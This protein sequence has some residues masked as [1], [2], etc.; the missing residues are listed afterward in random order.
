MMIL[1]LPMSLFSYSI[2]LGPI[3]IP[4]F[5]NTIESEIDQTTWS[6][7]SQ[8][9]NLAS[10]VSKEKVLN[11]Q[12]E[13]EQSVIIRDPYGRSMAKRH[14]LSTDDQG[15][16]NI[17]THRWNK[18]IYFVHLNSEHSNTMYKLILE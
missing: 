11:I 2:D 7:I 5:V 18:G 14:F 13:E 16:T 6:L 15:I 3:R 10:F 9:E 8:P 12:L 1:L 4:I 17:P